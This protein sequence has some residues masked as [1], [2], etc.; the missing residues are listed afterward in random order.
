MYCDLWGA[1]GETDKKFGVVD[2]TGNNFGYYER[3]SMGFEV[4]T[5]ALRHLRLCNVISATG[6]NTK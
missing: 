6:G 2:N 4:S 3:I 5:P 1:P